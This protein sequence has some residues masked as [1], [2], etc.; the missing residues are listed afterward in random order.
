MLSVGSPVTVANHLKIVL[1]CIL[2]LRVLNYSMCTSISNH[3]KIVFIKVTC[4][5]L[6]TYVYM[7][8]CILN[9]Q[10]GIAI[11]ILI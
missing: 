1:T 2:K 6:D 5:V 9:I 8:I 4:T 10:E 3:R 11:R 7:Y